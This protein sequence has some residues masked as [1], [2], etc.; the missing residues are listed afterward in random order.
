M[1]IT[2]W[3]SSV[4]SL[5]MKLGLVAHLLIL[6]G[7][8]LI[9]FF[10]FDNIRS[11]LLSPFSTR[12]WAVWILLLLVFITTLLYAVRPV[13]NSDTLLYHAQAIHWIEEY[14]AVPGLGNIEPRLGSNSNWFTL[15]ALFSFSFLGSQ[16][17]H[18]LPSFLFLICVFYFIG[19][20]ENLLKRDFRLSQFVKTGFIP[21][22]FYG[23]L[24]ELSS[25]GTDLPVILYYWLVL[26]L[27]LELLEQKESQL[28]HVAVFFLSVMVVT[29]KLSGILILLVSVCILFDL[30]RQRKYGLV[31]KHAAFAVIALLPWMIRTFILTGYWLYPEPVVQVFSPH[32]DWMIPA[33]RVLAF[34]QG[35]QAW[36]LSRGTLWEDIADLSFRQRLAYWFSDLTPN[37][38]GIAV[39]A[40]TSS[41]LCGLF[42][43]LPKR[44][45]KKI[46]YA[47]AMA[48]SLL[49][50]L[51]WLL[52]APNFRFGYGFVV[53]IIVLA[54]AP[55]IKFVFEYSAKYNV[56]LI[57]VIA[58]ILLAQQ[59]RVI[60]GATGDN[61]SYA[62]YLVMPADYP[63]VRTDACSLDG[64]DIFCAHAP[65]FCSYHAF[66]CVR[67][68]PKNVELRGETFLDGFRRLTINP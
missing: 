32:V 20:I 33:E 2:A 25:P 53:G 8:F 36:A 51:F 68:I 52:T 24:D 3:I 7:A 40:L 12:R 5:V 64:V 66:P 22:A 47:P 17:L 54:L 38:K 9:V 30:A 19:G 31:W 6:A 48:L 62:Q 45:L 11:A 59:V 55:F 16:S 23:L 58:L 27:W 4:L 56:S 63:N 37:R 50:F 21:L 65:T 67:Q 43:M 28:L 41:I 35:V 49:C 57:L 18:L 46:S 42:S 44:D 14:R 26:C 39:M 61:A 29:F 60:L 15:N 34:K 10:H 13:E 1:A